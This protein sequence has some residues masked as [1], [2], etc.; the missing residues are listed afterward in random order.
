LVRAACELIA[1][2]EALRAG[3]ADEHS[4]WLLATLQPN[5]TFKAFEFELGHFFAGEV[6]AADPVLRAVYRPASDLSRPNFGATLLLVAPESNNN[7]LAIAFADPSF[8]LGWTELVLGWLLA[9]AAQQV[10][11]IIDSEPVF[12]VSP[13]RR[14][15]YED[16]QRR[17]AEA[18]SRDDRCRVEEVED[19]GRRRYLIHD[20]RRA[21]SGSGKKILL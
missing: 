12:P 11:L 15:E 8:H 13:E 20:F 1:A 21:A 10:K 2:Q 14:A 19:A 16:L 4:K 6:L 9:L 17:V 18:L 7:R 3:Q 5:E